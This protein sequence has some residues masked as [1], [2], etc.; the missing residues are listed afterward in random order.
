[1]QVGPPCAASLAFEPAAQLHQPHPRPMHSHDG[2][3]VELVRVEAAPAVGVEAEPGLSDDVAATRTGSFLA[4]RQCYAAA[5]AP[6]REKCNNPEI[7]VLARRSS[8]Q[9]CARA[10]SDR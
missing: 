5:R 4:M 8:K 9:C 10:R 2:S 3:K 7:V 1:M 6:R